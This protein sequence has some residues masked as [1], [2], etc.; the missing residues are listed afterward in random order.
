M[1]VL[2]PLDA[3]LRWADRYPAEAHNELMRME[4]SAML[5][6]LPDLENKTILDLACGSGR[7]LEIACGKRAKMVCGLD[8]SAPMLLHAKRASKNLVLADMSHIPMDSLSFDVIICGLAIGHCLELEPVFSEISRIL[9]P[10]GL[11]I[12]SDLHPFGKIAGWKRIFRDVNGREVSVRHYFHLYN[13]HHRACR[14]NGLV[15]E[16]IREPLIEGEHRWS[17][18]PAVLAVRARKQ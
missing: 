3:Y 10:G 5:G 4:Q 6:L 11:V 1:P 12:Y 16:D 18:S 14:K 15:I 9:R 17:G 13:E 8:F 7:Y 2:D